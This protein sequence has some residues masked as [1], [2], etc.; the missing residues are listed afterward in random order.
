MNRPSARQQRKIQ[1]KP[2]TPSA[3]KQS[4]SAPSNSVPVAPSMGKLSISDAIGLITIRLSKLEDFM[5]RMEGNNNNISDMNTLTRSLANRV[6]SLESCISQQTEGE[7]IE[8]HETSSD[9]NSWELKR[10]HII[11]EMTTFKTDLD[12]IRKLVIKIQTSLG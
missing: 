1:E 2:E 12:D 9:P 3:V 7:Y 4:L 5:I 6:N 10:D 11:G 8:Q